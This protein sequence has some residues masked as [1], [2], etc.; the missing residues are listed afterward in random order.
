MIWGGILIDPQFFWVGR[1]G[2]FFF[3]VIKQRIFLFCH[4][5]EMFS[6]DFTAT[7][8]SFVVVGGS[9]A[10]GNKRDKLINCTP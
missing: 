2:L 1:S 6:A 10:T 5:K 3:H 4:R 8:L 9:L 7:W